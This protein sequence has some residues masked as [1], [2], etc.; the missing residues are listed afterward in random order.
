MPRFR[1]PESTSIRFL[2]TAASPSGSNKFGA[3]ES[4]YLKVSGL[5]LKVD[6]VPDYNHFDR[7]VNFSRIQFPYDLEIKH[8]TSD[9]G[10]KIG[11]CHLDRDDVS[12]LRPEVWYLEVFSDGLC[13]PTG[14][15]LQT[16]N[17]NPAEFVRVG[18]ATT[19][20]FK[21]GEFTTFSQ[22]SSL[23]G[24]CRRTITIY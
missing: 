4:G 23:L 6:F 1:S 17:E 10:L 18:V 24:A 21:A 15:L 7:F 2:E 16:T 19:N 3:V 8:G 9:R 13:K 20:P 11:E 12:I 5:M 14:L 22:A